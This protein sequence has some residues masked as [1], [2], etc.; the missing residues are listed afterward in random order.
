MNR[1]EVHSTKVSSRKIT[2]L[3]KKVHKRDEFIEQLQDEI[4]NLKAALEES[5]KMRK[6]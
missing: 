4:D 6:K 2:K 5:E 3:E 1:D